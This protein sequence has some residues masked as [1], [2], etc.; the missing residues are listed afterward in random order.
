[1]RP[2]LSQ[3]TGLR[4]QLRI[5][6]GTYVI[7]NTKSGVLDEKNYAAIIEALQKY[8]EPWEEVEAAT[9]PGLSPIASRDRAS[10]SLSGWMTRMR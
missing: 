4:Q 6:P 1:M 8:E 10:S 7:L 2:G 3:Q 5:N 9:V